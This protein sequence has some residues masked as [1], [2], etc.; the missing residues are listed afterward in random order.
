[1]A[2]PSQ[3]FKKRQRENKLREKAQLKRE[4]RAQRQADR[5]A[6]QAADGQDSGARLDLGLIEAEEQAPNELSAESVE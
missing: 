1:M 5:K 4:R 3:T 6:S 2:K